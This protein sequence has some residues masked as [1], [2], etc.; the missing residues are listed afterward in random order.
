[1]SR[2]VVVVLIGHETHS[3]EW[4]NW[5]IEQAHK[6]GKRIVGVWAHGAQ[7]ADLPE[8]LTKYG[9]AVVG[10]Q[11]DRIVDAIDGKIDNWQRP[12]G[13]ECPPRKIARIACQ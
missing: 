4:V 9:D 2:W 11:V 7:E 8:S 13:Q 12:D 6:Q 1:M 3:R 10:W 5:E